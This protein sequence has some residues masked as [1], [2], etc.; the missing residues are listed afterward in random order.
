M[1]TTW[2]PKHIF[3]N[4]NKN[5]NKT[6]QVHNFY[7]QLFPQE[8]HKPTQ[9]SYSQLQ[10]TSMLHTNYEVLE[11]CM[12]VHLFICLQLYLWTMKVSQTIQYRMVGS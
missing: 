8:P 10:H 7:F 6:L 2:P 9:N 12:Y 3:I 11:V 1:S 5:T 4:I